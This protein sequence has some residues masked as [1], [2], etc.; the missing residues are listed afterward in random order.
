[1]MRLELA[2]FVAVAALAGCGGDEPAGTGGGARP[3][4]TA[5][6][7]GAQSAFVAK[8]D[9]ICAKA[10]EK[11]ARLG[12]EGPGW[13][14]GGQFND[15]DFLERLTDA[16]RGALRELE[17]LTPPADNRE[18]MTTMLDAIGRMVKA[19]DSRI[20]VLRAGREESS[21][22]RRYDSG[23]RDL[24]TAAATLGLSE[25]QGVLL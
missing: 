17:K 4:K 19:L 3:T 14:Y 21:A 20:S 15:V 1:M 16:G 24:V 18:S 9:A 8:A 6:T 2:A 22:V 11:E 5:T 13:I 23:Y 25:C 7:T 10:N 12:A